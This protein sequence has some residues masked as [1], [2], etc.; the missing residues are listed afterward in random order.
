[1]FFIA[2]TRLGQWSYLRTGGEFVAPA[3]LVGRERAKEGQPCRLDWGVLVWLLA[4]EDHQ[5]D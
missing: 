1:M 4:A 3:V 2:Q 5:R